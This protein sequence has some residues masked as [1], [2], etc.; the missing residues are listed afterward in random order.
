MNHLRDI[1]LREIAI[2][3]E[4]VIFARNIS[5]VSHQYHQY[6]AT[7]ISDYVS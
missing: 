1:Q 3:R 6:V 7:F 4:I 5:S 2:I